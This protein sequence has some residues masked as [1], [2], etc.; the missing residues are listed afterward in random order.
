MPFRVRPDFAKAKCKLDLICSIEWCKR[1]QVSFVCH[2]DLKLTRMRTFVFVQFRGKN[3]KRKFN[4]KETAKFHQQNRTV[5]VITDERKHVTKRTQSDLKRTKACYSDD[6]VTEHW[7]GYAITA[8]QYV[9]ECQSIS[10]I[11]M[12]VVMKINN[13]IRS[14]EALWISVHILT[15][16]WKSIS[17]SASHTHV[18]VSSHT[19][20]HMPADTCTHAHTLGQSTHVACNVIPT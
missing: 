18:Y 7:T 5:P 13:T 11:L 12:W 8:T 16:A 2:S 4:S 15:Y 19:H 1:F 20:R 10:F 17:Q 14:A 3:W 9:C 6:N